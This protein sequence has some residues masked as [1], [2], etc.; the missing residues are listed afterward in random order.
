[1]IFN[2]LNDVDGFYKD[3]ET[4]PTTKDE[5]KRTRDLVIEKAKDTFGDD[6]VDVKSS[7]NT[8]WLLDRDG[9]KLAKFFTLEGFKVIVLDSNSIEELD[10]AYVYPT[11]RYGEH[12]PPSV[13]VKVI[14]RRLV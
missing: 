6:L 2:V 5:I 3:Q 12:Q 10:R 13:E 11:D 7:F 8:H 1:M 14:E 4:R 9:S